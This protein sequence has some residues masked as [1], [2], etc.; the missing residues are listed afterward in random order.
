MKTQKREI[1]IKV[2]DQ[3]INLEWKQVIE[4]ASSRHYAKNEIPDDAHERKN[5][6]KTWD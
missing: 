3:L 6:E 5:D 4:E 2:K 1:S